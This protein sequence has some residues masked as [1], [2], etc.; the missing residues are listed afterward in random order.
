[1]RKSWHFSQGLSIQAGYITWAFH[2]NV[3]PIHAAW[4]SHIHRLFY[5]FNVHNYCLY[6]F[7]NALSVIPSI[8]II[9]HPAVDHALTFDFI[10]HCFAIFRLL[11]MTIGC[12]AVIHTFTSVPQHFA[13]AE[14][15]WEGFNFH[16]ECGSLSAAG[17]SDELTGYV[18]SS[19]K[20]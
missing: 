3:F 6:L 17:L 13:W 12:P 5:S 15:R 10:E 16:Y 14:L 2:L 18:I 11:Y 19:L 9:Y 1:M 20:N 7:L 4:Y 8:I